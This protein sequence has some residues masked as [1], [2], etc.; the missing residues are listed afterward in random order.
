M[1]IGHGELLHVR[2]TIENVEVP[3]IGA[4]ITASEGGGPA[5]AQI[6]IIPTDRALNLR[7]RSMVKVFFLDQSLSPTGDSDEDG[8][9][10]S[11]GPISYG[12]PDSFYKLVF[13]GELF[14]VMLTKSGPGSRSVVLQCLD[15]SNQIDTAFLYQTRYGTEGGQESIINSTQQFRGQDSSAAGLDDIITSVEWLVERLSRTPESGAYAGTQ[16][17]LGGVLSIMEV[18]GGVEGAA[19]G[20]DPWNTVQAT[21][22]RLMD[23][24]GTDSGQTARALLQL[25][26]TDRFLRNSLSEMGPVAS[27]RQAVDTLLGYVMYAMVPNPV[28]TYKPGVRNLAAVR[29][30][31][32]NKKDNKKLDPE[33]AAILERLEGRL[34][35]KGWVAGKRGAFVQTSAYRTLEKRNAIQ[36]RQGKPILAEKPEKAHDWGYAADYSLKGVGI[37]FLF[38]VQPETDLQKA[39]G[40]GLY[41]YLIS[42]IAVYGYTSWNALKNAGHITLEEAAKVEKLAAFYRDLGKVAS[43]PD[44]NLSWGGF[45]GYQ[46]SLLWSLFQFAGGD[47][48][49]VQMR[50]WTA[51]RD[52]RRAKRAAAPVAAT[53]TRGGDTPVA[54]DRLITQFVRPDVWF[55]SPPACNIVFPEEVV[56]L[57]FTRQHMRE[58]TRMQVTV[59]DTHIDD[60]VINE[61]VFSP[62]I[63]DVPSLSRGGLGSAAEAL[64][65]R[66]EKFSGIVP[67]V[68]RMSAISMYARANIDGN[69]GEQD[70]L[71]RWAQK[72]TDYLLLTNRYEARTLTVT[73]KF[74]PRLAPGWPA[75]VVDRT[76][77]D[78]SS[79][80]NLVTPTHFLGTI[81][82]ISHSL[83]QAGGQTSFMLGQAR[84]HKTGD[85]TDDL[86]S[87]ELYGSSE[88]LSRSSLAEWKLKVP[89]LVQE[90]DTPG[91][92][93]A[94]LSINKEDRNVTAFLT[95]LSNHLRAGGALSPLPVE[96]TRFDPDSFFLD[97]EITTAGAVEGPYGEVLVSISVEQPVDPERS[98][99]TS[100]RTE[101]GWELLFSRVEIQFTLPS[102]RIPLEEAIR[103]PW[104]SEE[105]SNQRIGE[106]YQELLGCRALVDL[107]TPP[108]GQGL[109]VEA[110]TDAVVKEYS[111][112]ANRGV[113]S[114]DFITAVTER[115]Y[116]SLVDVIGNASRPGFFYHS[117]GDVENLDGEFFSWMKNGSATS[118]LN[119][120]SSQV[121]SPE[122]DPR[123]DR[124]SRVIEYVSEL[125]EG[126]AFQG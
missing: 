1:S 40:R 37:N 101:E 91:V 100:L 5:A 69:S 25:E 16:G 26:S 92:Y 95:K 66:H 36:A 117:S 90:I 38:A 113:S 15:F 65:Y 23:Q 104:V 115:D 97:T 59:F 126:R 17:M 121:V 28:A 54:R 4:M 27:F 35:E 50:N 57:S 6:E 74:M 86:F 41:V 79:P 48:V 43:E 9:F 31:A 49:H 2:M 81:R 98:P 20:L 102:G 107:Y 87:K 11:S 112:R 84:S 42:L 96:W 75:L 39:A 64:L 63:E 94:V 71:R 13:S 29:S 72:I 45:K 103:P 70:V 3:V 110:A 52:A 106:L 109:S 68:E 67:K 33:F 125:L 24:F 114:K 44:I 62:Q 22:T 55:V 34:R 108:D 105:Y 111:I 73:G 123:K 85:S 12:H 51:K 32:W 8:L 76:L 80:D 99:D 82:S 78:G 77:P 21:R 122:V 93:S 46:P 7:A 61:P 124:Y 19:V 119:A 30:G 83:T 88:V 10:S 120:D 53:A 58:T 89:Y 18:L 14:T 118:I 56:S 116:A 47:P 60:A